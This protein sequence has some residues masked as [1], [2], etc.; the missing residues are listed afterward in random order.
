M[1]HPGHGE[2]IY[3]KLPVIGLLFELRL[4][5]DVSVFVQHLDEP[6]SVVL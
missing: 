3:L 5:F 4:P 2:V 6:G 1:R